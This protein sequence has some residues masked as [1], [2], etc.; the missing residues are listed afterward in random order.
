MGRYSRTGPARVW[1]V[2][3]MSGP[4]PTPAEVEAG[5]QLPVESVDFDLNTMK[6]RTTWERPQANPLKDMADT[7]AAIEAFQLRTEDV[8]DQFRAMLEG[9]ARW[10]AQAGTEQFERATGH[11][12][13]TGEARAR[14][15]RDQ[16]EP[17]LHSWVQP[18]Q[19]RA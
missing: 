5:R 18:R 4:P 12:P 2:P 3:E 11:R 9:A 1:F 7:I 16:L 8:S 14:H 13:L 19:N 6:M 17:R 15:W 10:A